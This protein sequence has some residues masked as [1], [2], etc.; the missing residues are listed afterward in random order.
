[1]FVEEQGGVTKVVTMINMILLGKTFSV[2]WRLLISPTTN[3]QFKILL[4]IFL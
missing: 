1:M 3:A 4:F 2:L